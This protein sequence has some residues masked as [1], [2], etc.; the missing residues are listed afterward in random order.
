MLPWKT[1]I[2]MQ[3]DC[4]TPV[5]LQ[6]ANS[7]IHEMRKGRVG[8]G[9]KLPGTRQMAEILEV[10]RKT[11]VRAYEEL[12]AQGWIEM[13]PSKGTF[14]SKE[15]PEINGRHFTKNHNQNAFPKTTGYHVKVN[16]GIRT[17]VLPLRHIMGFH[18]GP[19]M[20]LIPS[21]ELGRAYKSVLSRNT[22]LKFMSYVET[23]G[24]QKFRATLSEYLNASRGLQTTFE[25]IIVT[26][27]SQ[28]A[29]YLLSIVLF[30]KGDTIIVGD[31]NYYYADHV[32]LLAGMKLARIK[33][34][35]YGIDVDAIE[36]LCRKKKIKALYITSHHHYPTTVTLSAARRIKLL[37]LAEKYGFIIIEDDYDYDF[38]YLSSPMLP[39]VSADTKG[40]VVYIGTLSK[41]I[42]PAIRTGYII[43]PENLI[44]ELMRVRQLIDT[45]GDP[46]MELALIE[47]FEEGHIKRH[48]KKALLAYHKRRDFLCGLLNEKLGDIIDF[49][50]PD[51]GLAIWAKFHKSIPLPPLTEKLKAK[52]LILS[53]G[54]IHNTSSVSMN[55]TRMGFG[56][57]NEEEA[58]QA[59]DLLAQT[60]R[61][62]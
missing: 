23:P 15:L 40:M 41:T 46:I 36:K 62:K 30:A 59:V 18:D 8:P 56:W 11:I 19:D 58:A 7:V 22:Y 27:G 24:V 45:Q 1:I 4:D 35:E 43:A 32:F 31:T 52:G 39:L 55:A 9:L 47:M 10:H 26:R 50:T 6:I 20:R 54:L 42:A 16:T 38:H 34:D 14:T 28:M 3:K 2:Q 60:I 49:K 17:P 5:Y 37:S 51:G 12:D 13:H 44:L 48:M 57:M 33:V 21:D 29:L 25:N 61:S 53:N